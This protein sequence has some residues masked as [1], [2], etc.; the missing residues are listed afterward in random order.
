MENPEVI[1]HMGYISADVAEGDFDGYYFT[2]TATETGTLSF[3]NYGTDTE[4]VETDL[5]VY[6]QSSGVMKQFSTDKELDQYDC[7]VVFVPVNEGDIVSIQLIALPDSS[8]NYPAATIGA[9][10]MLETPAGTENNPITMVENPAQVDVPAGSTIYCQGYLNGMIVDILGA[11]SNFSVTYNGLVIPAANNVVSLGT[12]SAPGFRMPVVFA[13]T[14]SGSVDATYTVNAVAAPGTMDNPENLTIGNN[15]ADIAEG[16][17]GYFYTWTATANGTLTITMP[18][19]NWFYVINN[20]TANKYGDYQ[21]SD[22]DPVVNPAIIE[23][24]AGDQIVI[25]A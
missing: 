6:N 17:D 2:W 18:E 4:G 9:Y 11:D 14:N 3:E 20:L 1:E 7:W 21:Y 22:S 23:V 15:T 19:G 5:I 8:Y 24:S 25:Q 10:G 13:I 16:T 12:V